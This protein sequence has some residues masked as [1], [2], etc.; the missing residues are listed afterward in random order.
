MAATTAMLVPCHSKRRLSSLLCCWNL[1]P[2]EWRFTRQTFMSCCPEP[3]ACKQKTVHG[4]HYSR[5]RCTELLRRQNCR[6]VNSMRCGSTA[7]RLCI[8]GSGELLAVPTVLHRSQ[9]KDCTVTGVVDVLEIKPVQ[10]EYAHAAGSHHEAISTTTSNSYAE[11]DKPRFLC[12]PLGDTNRT[13]NQGHFVTY[14]Q[15]Q[16][17]S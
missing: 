7:L 6:K 9:T 3:V 15:P 13:H 16:H 1:E 4:L 2:S 10:P 14:G 17:V 5:N 12:R 11:A 8:A